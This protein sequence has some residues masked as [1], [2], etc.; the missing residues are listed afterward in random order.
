MRAEDFFCAHKEAMTNT[1]RLIYEVNGIRENLTQALCLLV[2]VFLIF[3]L[4]TNKK[5][6]L[7]RAVVFTATTLVIFVL[8]K[9]I[10][11][12]FSHI[13]QFTLSQSMLLSASFIFRIVDVYLSSDAGQLTSLGIFILSMLAVSTLRREVVST[14]QKTKLRDRHWTPPITDELSTVVMLN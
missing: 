7:K 10:M 1:A 11:S 2:S 5:E 12:A 3:A 6:G 13:L 8:F 9:D 14:G 4:F